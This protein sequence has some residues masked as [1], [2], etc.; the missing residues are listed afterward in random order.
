MRMIIKKIP[1]LYRNGHNEPNA[2]ELF[3]NAY[4]RIMPIIKKK[5]C[6]DSISDTAHRESEQLLDKL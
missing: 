6:I 2:T 3:E 1:L 4:N 5:R